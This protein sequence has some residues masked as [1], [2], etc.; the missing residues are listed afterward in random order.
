MTN[1]N[2]QPTLP[3]RE[4]ELSFEE[5]KT[6]VLQ[7]Y[8]IAVESRMA[9]VLGRKE[10]LTGKAKFGIFG[11]GKELPQIAMA[12]VFQKGDFRSGYYR[13]QTFM[14]ASGLATISEFFAQLYANTDSSLEPHSSGRSMSCHYAT[15]SLHEDGTWKN[16]VE[17]KNTS[18]DISPT[19][20]QM[21]RLLGLAYA[22]K[23]YR[24]NKDLAYLNGFS[25]HGNEIAFGTIGNASTS[26][27]LF[28]ETFNAAGVLQIPMLISVWDD[29]YGISVPAKYHTTKE[30]IS[31][32]LKG[33]LRDEKHH[34]YEIF[35]VKG[36]DYS[37]LCQVYLEAAQICRE[38]HIPVLVHV[39]ELTQPQGHSTSGSH[40][41]Y[42]DTARLEWESEF[43]CN[44]Q[45]RKWMLESAISTEEELNELEETCKKEVKILQKKAWTN[46]INPILKDRDSLLEVLEDL[47]KRISEKEAIEDVQNQLKSIL[48]PGYKDIFSSIRRAFW[49]IRF[50]KEE[51]KKE[52]NSH[53]LRIKKENFDRFNSFLFTNTAESAFKIKSV[54]PVFNQNSPL[55]DGREIL[56]ACFDA[57]MARDPRILVFGEDVGKIGDV[58]QGFAGLQNKYG[59]LRVIDTG[60]REATIIGQGI[61]LALRGLRPIAEIQYLDYLLFALEILSDDLAGLSFR[62]KGG[63]KAPLIIRTRGHRLEGTFHAGSPMGLIINAL[64][65]IHII[66]PRNMTQAAGFYNT[67]LASDEP[68]LLIECLNG[69]RIKENLPDNIGEFKIPIGIPEILRE[70]KDITLITY[71]SC[72]RVAMEACLYL[73]EVGIEVE[74][75]DVQTL[76]PFDLEHSLVKSLIKTNKV[77][78]IDE[79]MPG[80][81][82]GYMMQQVLEIQKGY[83]YLDAPPQTLTAKEHRTAY[84]SDGDYF[85]KPGVDDIF[86]KVYTIMSEF[87]PDRLPPLF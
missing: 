66:T 84:G 65:G 3:I 86:E 25:N 11:D 33:F 41:R 62:T 48:E 46:F 52:L 6:I 77:L 13:D 21:P 50:E 54:P 70:G 24:E 57:A 40:E 17:M 23:M 75:I 81:A 49:L 83:Y 79:D 74:L 53:F 87:S 47:K 8:K 56:K 51:V 55:L 36:W 39:T 2:A 42:K 18:A 73:Q 1:L 12:K 19:G 63:Q 78:F 37:A 34:G 69:Y 61:G 14:F 82:S 64:R 67:L 22:S 27:G 30:S 32:A 15:R 7:D 68:A 76:L 38:K 5:F 45:M 44:L 9:S 80:G 60:I 29:E 16:L 58:N 26:E 85:T 20:G 71:G 10:V 31:E 72:C 28:F 4:D 43:D 59:E 35:Q